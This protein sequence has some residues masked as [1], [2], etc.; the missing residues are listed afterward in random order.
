MTLKDM[1]SDWHDWDGAEF[2]VAVSLG[3]ME[4]GYESYQKNKGTFWTANPLGDSLYQIL[5]EL[6]KMGLVEKRDEPDDQYR[7]KA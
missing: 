7:W 4:D 2:A 6:V 3:I 5:Q 1:L